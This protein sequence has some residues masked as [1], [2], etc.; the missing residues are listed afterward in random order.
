MPV[1]VARRS[2]NEIMYSEDELDV[3]LFQPPL[4]RP[5]FPEDQDPVFNQYLGVVTG[6]AALMNDLGT[7]PNHGLLQLAAILIGRRHQDRCL[8][9]PRPGH[10]APPGTADHQRG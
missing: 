10:R 1:P 7:E 6:H 5:I 9:L 2:I 3:A 8:R 4:F